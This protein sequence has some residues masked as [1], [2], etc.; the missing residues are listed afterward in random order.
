VS[1]SGGDFIPYRVR[2][3]IE[4]PDTLPK[5]TKPYELTFRVLLTDGT[6]EARFERVAAS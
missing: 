3:K 1:R 6:R 2:H 5:N 4:L